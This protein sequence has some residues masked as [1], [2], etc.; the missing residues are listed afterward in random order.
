MKSREKPDWRG[1]ERIIPAILLEQGWDGFFRR[2]AGVTHDLAGPVD[3]DVGGDAHDP[4]LLADLSA[5]VEQHR[6]LDLVFLDESLGNGV[7]PAKIQ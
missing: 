7:C 2:L 6:V 4:V 5:S 1:R 3:E